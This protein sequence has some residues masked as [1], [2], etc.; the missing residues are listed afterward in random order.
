MLIGVSSTAG[1][2][3]SQISGTNTSVHTGCFTF[4]YAW[5]LAKDPE[6]MPKYAAPGGAVSM[7][8]N[9]ISTFFNL[10]G[11]SVT[12]DTACS[13]SLVA[14]DQACRC[15]RQGESSMVC[16]YTCLALCF[17]SSLF[18]PCF[19]FSPPP[20]PLFPPSFFFI[21]FHFF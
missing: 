20:S 12:V 18:F 5:A 19:C 15:I 8:S 6:Y 13:S 14:L 9:R 2:P 21:S 1:I 11:P 4:D 10:S 17:A 3:L 16:E 7:L